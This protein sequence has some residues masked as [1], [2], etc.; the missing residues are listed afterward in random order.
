MP[1]KRSPKASNKK[2]KTKKLKY[3]AFLP[4]DTT[5]MTELVRNL[6]RDEL[7]FV[8]GNELK[9]NFSRI[10]NDSYCLLDTDQDI[11]KASEISDVLNN[12]YFYDFSVIPVIK[13]IGNQIYF[14]IQFTPRFVNAFND[15]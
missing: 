10:L 5:E 13:N 2:R 8:L 7:E 12:V 3:R 1:I 9:C 6:N 11:K 14:I 4:T 15:L